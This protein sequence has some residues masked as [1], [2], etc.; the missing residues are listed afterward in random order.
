MVEGVR[1]GRRR[2]YGET[3][4]GVLLDASAILAVLYGEAGEKEI[5]QRIRGVRALV[6]TVNLS[7][8][9]GKLAEGGFDE[10]EV[11]EAVG[12]LALE[13]HPLDEDAAYLAGMLRP[14]TRERGMGVAD[15][16]CVAVARATGATALTT[17][18]SW[19]GL[20]GVEVIAR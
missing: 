14:R 5:R 10:R 12:L 15:R 2:R 1:R 6:S 17:D 11:R 9:A 20:E 7:E 18:A 13:V 3:R 16:V 4:G 8:V 19:E